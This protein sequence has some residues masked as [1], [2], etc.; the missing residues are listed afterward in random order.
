MNK[1]KIIKTKDLK[2]KNYRLINNKRE[3]NHRG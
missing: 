2:I 1:N 3:E